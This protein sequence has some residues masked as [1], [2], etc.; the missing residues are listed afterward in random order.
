[1]L[2]LLSY[3]MKLAYIRQRYYVLHNRIGMD[4]AHIVIY[5][6]REPACAGA[7][8]LACISA[9][10]SCLCCTQIGNNPK[11]PVANYRLSSLPICIPG[12]LT[13]RLRLKIH[14]QV[15]EIEIGNNG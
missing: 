2:R 13:V 7:S 4:T 1:M 8:V 11:S 9:G 3:T 12:T 6:Y 14:L 10:C 15:R 5:S